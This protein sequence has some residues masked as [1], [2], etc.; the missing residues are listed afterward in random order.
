M[1][2]NT[3]HEI[4]RNT[5]NFEDLTAVVKALGVEHKAM[6]H[7]HE[8]QTYFVDIKLDVAGEVHINIEDPDKGF[9][10]TWFPYPY[11]WSMKGRVDYG[12]VSTV[13]AVIKLIQGILFEHEAK[14]S[15]VAMKFRSVD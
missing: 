3:E 13:A 14:L 11:T 2:K 4:N 15:N 10:V 6:S 1:S 8:S 12:Y 9:Q 7:S 5:R